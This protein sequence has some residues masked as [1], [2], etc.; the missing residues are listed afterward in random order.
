MDHNERHLLQCATTVISAGR[1]EPKASTCYTA[2]IVYLQSGDRIR[3][4]DLLRHYAL[5]K[6]ERSFFGLVR[7]GGGGGGNGGGG[8]GG[9]AR[10]RDTEEDEQADSS[11]S[12]PERNKEAY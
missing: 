4:H 10:S 2:G 7:I 8:G 11:A 9:F 6:A 5:L 1:A 3:V 12:L